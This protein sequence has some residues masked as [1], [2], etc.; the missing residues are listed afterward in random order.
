MSLQQE[1]PSREITPD[2]IVH[3]SN[4]DSSPIS[5]SGGLVLSAKN[6]QADHFRVCTAVLFPSSVLHNC[7]WQCCCYWQSSTFPQC[8]IGRAAQPGWGEKGKVRALIQAAGQS[9]A[10]D[11]RKNWIWVKMKI[12]KTSTESA[13]FKSPKSIDFKISRSD[14]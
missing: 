14:F 10:E 11:S 9:E 6:V 4:I 7:T 12:C 5:F 13:A 2:R 8:A 1:N 3:T